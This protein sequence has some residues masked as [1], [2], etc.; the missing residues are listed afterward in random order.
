MTQKR[1][2]RGRG[3]PKLAGKM[4]RLPIMLTLR[5]GKDDDLIEWFSNIPSRQRAR[6]VSRALR[7]SCTTDFDD[8]SSDDSSDYGVLINLLNLRESIDSDLLGWL[9]NIP[10]GEHARYIKTALRQGGA[11]FKEEL[12]QDEPLEFIDN[13]AFDDLLDG[14]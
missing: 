6:V 5:S 12:S 11:T 4:V 2:S 13:N 1:S 7:M 8:S 9:K 14:F 3:R 10:A